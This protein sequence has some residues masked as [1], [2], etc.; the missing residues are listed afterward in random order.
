MSAD[1]T[2]AVN[3]GVSQPGSVTAVPSAAR[4]RRRRPWLQRVLTGRHYDDQ[5]VVYRHSNLVY[6]WPVWLLGF[7]FAAL[8]YF[9]DHHLA[10]V[11]AGT[12]AAPDRQVEVETSEGQL[13][14]QKRDVLIL[15]AKHRLLK[16]TDVEGNTYIVQPR[17][18]LPSHRLIGTVYMFVLLLVV[19]LTTITLRGLWSV[20]VLMTLVLLVIILYL[21]SAL[22]P[23]FANIGQLSIYINMGGYLMISLVLFALW[24]LNFFFLDRMTYMI[25]T[26][27][28]VRVRLEIG[29]GEMVYDATSMTVQKQ[30]ADMFRHWL[31][32]L[33]SGDL[34][35]FPLNAPHPIEL[36]NVLRVGQVVREIEQMVKEKVVVTTE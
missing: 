15:D 16:R 34:L 29:G 5:V 6:W 27:G 30:R 25:F 9:G 32:G 11:P 31:L 13:E 17:I 2:P 24:A 19:V 35:I 22:R 10:I 28:Q 26:P 23:V 20:L 4:Q 3:P 1:P 7:I 12:V 18:Y 8:S 36:P 21:S 14:L 33:G